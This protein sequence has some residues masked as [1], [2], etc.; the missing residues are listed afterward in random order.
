MLGSP[1]LEDKLAMALE[2]GSTGSVRWQR[3]LAEASDKPIQ[4]AESVELV[5]ELIQEELTGEKSDTNSAQSSAVLEQGV[6][7]LLRTGYNYPETSIQV[8]Q[9]LF[10]VTQSADLVGPRRA[11]VRALETIAADR[12]GYPLADAVIF[13]D[14]VTETSSVSL[15]NSESAVTEE[16]AATI[17]EQGRVAWAAIRLN[18]GAVPSDDESLEPVF[19]PRSARSRAIIQLAIDSAVGRTDSATWVS[20]L[21]RDG[22]NQLLPDLERLSHTDPDDR[23]IEKLQT[24]LEVIKQVAEVPGL[25]STR[26]DY[27]SS[28][29]DRELNRDSSEVDMLVGKESLSQDVQREALA[30]L[31]T[32]ADD[33]PHTLREAAP[34]LGRL[35]LEEQ[36]EPFRTQAAKIL[37]LAAENGLW[38][39]CGEA[40]VLIT[41]IENDLEYLTPHI[42][43]AFEAGLA[44]SEDSAPLVIEGLREVVQNES[45]NEFGQSDVEAAVAAIG[46]VARQHPT[47]GAQALATLTTEEDRAVRLRAIRCLGEVPRALDQVRGDIEEAVR[48]LVKSEIYDDRSGNEASVPEITA[49]KPNPVGDAI[50]NVIEQDE[51]LRT[52]VLEDLL[53]AL[54]KESADTGTTLEILR[55]VRPGEEDP[56]FRREFVDQLWEIFLR[57]SDHEKSTIVEMFADRV[58]TD[59]DGSPQIADWIRKALEDDSEDTRAKTADTIVQLASESVN[60]SPDIVDILQSRLRQDESEEVRSSVLKGLVQ[61]GI[62]E[63][64]TWDIALHAIHHAL[65]DCDDGVRSAALWQCVE[66]A[67]VEPSHIPHLIRE[68]LATTDRDS[69]E[70]DF[71]YIDGD[72]DTVVSRLMEINSTYR[73]V[74][75]QEVFH[76]LENGMVPRQASISILAAID[77][78]ALSRRS[79]LTETLVNTVGEPGL[80]E[81]SNEINSK[82]FFQRRNRILEQLVESDEL[83]AT[84]LFQQLRFKVQSSLGLTRLRAAELLPR[85][86]PD[87]NETVLRSI[88]D[89]VQNPDTDWYVRSK[90]NQALS[91]LSDWSED[92]IDLYVNVSEALNSQHSMVR[93]EAIQM[94]QERVQRGDDQLLSED[95]VQQLIY[96]YE[97]NS[98]S[99]TE[100][101]SVL[102]MITYE[103]PRTIENNPEPI[104]DMLV[105]Y[106]LLAYAAHPV[107]LDGPGAIAT[108]DRLLTE[109]AAV[110]E[111]AIDE[112]VRV[113]EGKRVE[114][115]WDPQRAAWVLSDLTDA[116]S[117]VLADRSSR[118]V[119]VLEGD[120]SVAEKQIADLLHELVMRSDIECTVDPERIRTIV[121]DVDHEEQSDSI[122]GTLIDVL[123]RLRRLAS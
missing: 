66:L 74:L 81:W 120:Q 75:V 103:A 44:T 113:V 9:T 97:S 34:T 85:I 121:S 30:A 43:R 99:R 18:S 7:V 118:L 91:E 41:A 55:E 107:Y 108:L 122:V 13:T 45:S 59:T 89:L 28:V 12:I 71:P 46:T 29:I 39:F 115:P 22:L 26:V 11:A 117:A 94:L 50:A 19:S 104:V 72:Y 32:I 21:D 40:E 1:D 98:P 93:N 35:I 83:L 90:T 106:S 119:T 51:R 4:A 102:S 84:A 2:E 100:L 14:L 114:D 25:G 78:K 79:A 48:R 31:R 38:D 37:E 56:E 3:V 62:Q 33:R 27:L 87:V 58:A 101:A 63:D 17:E 65:Q 92:D 112:L 15:E 36:H 82:Q 64:T 20:A 5:C 6:E 86:A 53:E 68:I 10:Q 54:G 80:D 105:D 57:S 67:E 109:S 52:M 24:E 77:Y 8:G 95:T 110:R 16:E 60:I 23:L 123:L 61:V 73:E 76:Q 47:L 96:Q 88:E 42:V 70:T 69:R 49:S 116:A 111:Y